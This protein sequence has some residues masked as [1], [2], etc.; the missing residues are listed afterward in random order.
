MCIVPTVHTIHSYD[1]APRLCSLLRMNTTGA[2]EKMNNAERSQFLR[3]VWGELFCYSGGFCDMQKWPVWWAH[4]VTNHCLKVGHDYHSLSKSLVPPSSKS[5][6]NG[7][8]ARLAGLE[9]MRSRAE[10]TTCSCSHLNAIHLA[11]GIDKGDESFPIAHTCFFSLDLPNY[12]S[13]EV[14]QRSNLNSCLYA[15]LCLVKLCVGHFCW[16]VFHAG[17]IQ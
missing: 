1:V 7:Q 9:L 15:V 2:M 14:W 10:V 16:R 13:V 8:G 17:G 12:S 4:T 6:Y 3:F 5:R 11:Q